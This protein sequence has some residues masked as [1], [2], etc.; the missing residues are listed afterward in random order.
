MLSQ[1]LNHL[2]ELRKEINQMSPELQK[3]TDKVAANNVVVESALTLIQGLADQIAALKNDPVALQALADS[4]D[5]EDTKLAAA[6]AANTPAT[7]A[8]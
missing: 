7:P 3:L 1:I 4:L 5:A 6:V 2:T 8:P